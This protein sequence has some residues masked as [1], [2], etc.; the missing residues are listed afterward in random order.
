MNAVRRHLTPSQRALIA[1]RMVTTEMTPGRPEKRSLGNVITREYAAMRMGVGLRIVSHARAILEH[2]DDSIITAV[3]GGRVA[4]AD[5]YDAVQAARQ[6]ERDRQEFEAR[7]ERAKMEAD[8][9][10]AAVQESAEELERLKSEIESDTKTAEAPAPQP[11]PEQ[12]PSLQ[13]K[14]RDE[15]LDK[16]IKQHEKKG[17]EARDA[18][19]EAAQAKV[20]AD[21]ARDVAEEVASEVSQ[22]VEG[23]MS[24]DRDRIGVGTTRTPTKR[25][26]LEVEVA[27]L[28]DRLSDCEKR[29]GVLRSKVDDPASVEEMDNLVR[30]IRTL[31]SQ[32]SHWMG[33]H[34]EEQRR[35][36]YFEKWAK[37]HGWTPAEIQAQ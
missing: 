2:G 3:D 17:V 7:A 34:E 18:K 5:A 37:D 22:G 27:E 28:R 15:Y 35:A 16:I 36:K 24:G 6:A 21:V 33:M 1:A 8:R 13:G 31:K 30:H 4:V 26:Q 11:E 10:A 32:V 12:S 23:V 25:Q 9:K 20:Q 29:E 14:E 19:V